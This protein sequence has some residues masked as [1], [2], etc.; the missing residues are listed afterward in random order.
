MTDEGGETRTSTA[1]TKTHA[2]RWLLRVLYWLAVLALSI[3]LLIAL[4]LFLESRDPTRVGAG[5]GGGVAFLL[6]LVSLLQV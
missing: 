3:A 4:V 1:P 6:A 5:E 2:A